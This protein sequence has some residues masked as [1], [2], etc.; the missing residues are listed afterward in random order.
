MTETSKKRCANCR[1]IGKEDPRTHYGDIAADGGYGE[2]E[3]KHRRCVR[4]LHGNSEHGPSALTELAF[5]V[6]GSGYAATLVV[7][8]TFSCALWEAKS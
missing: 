3:S 8:P 4:I 7:L 6:D 5:V 2:V 1:F